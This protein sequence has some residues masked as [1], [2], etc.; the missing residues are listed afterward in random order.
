MNVIYEPKGAAREYSEL[1][2]NL[3][4]GC[5][6]GCKYCY[7]PGIPPWKFRDNPRK[8]F[9]HRSFPRKDVIRKMAADAKHIY[10]DKREI[11]F[12]FTC[13]PYQVGRDN[14]VTTEALQICCDYRLSVQVLTKGGMEA[15]PDFHLMKRMNAKFATT[16]LFTDDECRRRWE[17]N[18]ATVS[19]R[20]EAIKAAHNC[21]IKTWVSIEPVIYPDQAIELIETLSEY[22]DFW[23]VG[24]LN[25]DQDTE[26]TIDWTAF[27]RNVT[28]A[29][30][31]RPHLIKDALLKYAC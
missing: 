9:H 26:S 15:A 22:V 27:Y 2:C 29:L 30:S 11:L 12:C 25:H 10:G 4:S 31:G 8:E 24:K 23:K 3:Y 5:E 20:I 18:A 17:P 16:L 14:S 19:S 28:M 21:G 13:D 6:H 1:A 7:V